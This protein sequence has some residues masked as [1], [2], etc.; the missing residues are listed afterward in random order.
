MKRYFI[1][2]ICILGVLAS[3]AF[4]S[5]T[6]NAPYMVLRT[7][8]DEDAATLAACIDLTTAGD[9]DSMDSAA[10]QLKTDAGR[11]EKS[12]LEIIFLGGGGNNYTFSWALYVWRNTNGP[13]RLAAY[14][15]GVLGTQAVVKYPHNKSTASSKWWADTLT[16]TESYLARAV[17]ASPGGH[18][19][20][21]SL[22]C[23]MFGYEYVCAKI[24]NAS[25]SGTEAGNIGVY[26]SY[27][28]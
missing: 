20:V 3:S 21:A 23:D 11:S 28:N 16:V 26:Y 15:T 18:N 6:Y 9:F 19:S 2:G 27:V 22:Q 24:Y 17:T 10:V 7:A 12:N 4:I 13:C 5:R 25:D 14:G 8:T 1:I